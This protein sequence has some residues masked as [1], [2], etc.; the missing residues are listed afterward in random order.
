MAALCLRQGYGGFPFWDFSRRRNS[1]ALCR[2]LSLFGLA[3]HPAA[4]T[5]CWLGVNLGSQDVAH[6]LGDSWSGLTTVCRGRCQTDLAA[7]NGWV[8]KAVVAL[9][10]V[11][12]LISLVFG[13]SLTRQQVVQ[14]CNWFL[15]TVCRG[16]SL[17]DTALRCTWR[18]S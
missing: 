3:R 4:M 13:L 2:L 12:R 7:R 18:R 17:A 6:Q 11:S 15:S 8:C 16:G 1:C 9:R 14:V 5:P 10:A